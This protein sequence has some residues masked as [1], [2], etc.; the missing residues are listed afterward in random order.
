MGT[1][2]SLASWVAAILRS[3][4]SPRLGAPPSRPG[5][6]FGYAP[7]RSKKPRTEGEQ[8]HGA[9][10]SQVW[11]GARPSESR[12]YNDVRGV[13]SVPLTMGKLALPVHPHRRDGAASLRRSSIH[14]TVFFMGRRGHSN[15]YRSKELHSSAV[16]IVAGARGG[17]RGD[18]R[19]L[20]RFFGFWAMPEYRRR[21]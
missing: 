19:I 4:T 15:L 3:S 12:H 17:L 7:E 8:P 9:G 20:A 13:S 18:R 16:F 6:S 1:I 2:G 14:S 10:S 21:L 11:L 5:F